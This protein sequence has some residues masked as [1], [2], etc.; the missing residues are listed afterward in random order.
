MSKANMYFRNV[1]DEQL[2]AEATTRRKA[3]IIAG[4]STYTYGY[5]AGMPAII[6]L[7]CGLGSVNENDLTQV[8]CGFCHAYHSDW[9]IR[10]QPSSDG[11][12]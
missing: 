7:C 2:R 11:H 10:P 5:S 8:Y 9:I 1:T 4:C 3:L 6:C 12:D